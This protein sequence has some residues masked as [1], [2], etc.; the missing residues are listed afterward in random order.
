MIQSTELAKAVIRDLQL[1]QNLFESWQMEGCSWRKFSSEIAPMLLEDLA[2]MQKVL[3]FLAKE[4]EAITAHILCEN[5]QVSLFEIVKTNRS[6]SS[7]VQQIRYELLPLLAEI[8]ND[9]YFWGLCY[10][11][12]E[13]VHQY[14]QQDMSYLCPLPDVRQAKYDLTILVAAWNKLE[15]TQLCLKH[16]FQYLPEDLNYELILLNH[17][18]S[19][20]TKE[21]FESIHP[22]KQINFVRNNKSL[23]ILGRVVEGR[24]V[25]FLSNDVLLMPNVIENL[26]TCLH[27]DSKIACVMPACPN[28][29]NLSSIDIKYN[30]YD[31]MIAAAT[32]N[33]Q[34]NPKRWIQRARLN[35]PVLMARAD[36]E[37][38]YT[39]LGYRYPFFKERFVAFTDDAMAMVA[40][41]AGKKCILAEDSY[42]HHFGSVTVSNQKSQVY[43]EGIKAFEKYFG[44]NPWGDGFC[45]DYELFSDFTYLSK[46]RIDIMG[47]NLGLGDNLFQLKCRLFEKT[48]CRKVKLTH[49]EFENYAF[50][51]TRNL[52]DKYGTFRRLYDI[53]EKECNQRF[54]YILVDATKEENPIL[55]FQLF[56][57]LSEDGI[58]IIKSN[59]IT[60]I[61]QLTWYK[62]CGN[63][64]V[65]KNQM[66]K[67]LFT[68]N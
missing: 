4:E 26:L 18:S 51:Q 17:G 41:K 40:R 54:T 57:L 11:D 10:P 14:Y 39:F 47:I 16:L 19:D 50:K 53:L 32:K 66:I 15:Y 5:T 52:V 63:W 9:L 24:N 30:N 38:F 35:P 58:L 49:Y 29:A 46:E 55:Y 1:Y 3:D 23:S 20:G 33:N 60:N 62:K 45:Y 59:N 65:F 67:E 37:A 28:I 12:K 48:K 27:S 13:R 22:T 61:E 42:V 43:V 21:Y 25:M 44:Y 7:K 34:S 31:E 64:Y 2:N 68:L 36:E 8:L 6:I 56:S